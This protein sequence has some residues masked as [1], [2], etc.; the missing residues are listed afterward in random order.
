MQGRCLL[1]LP[2]DTIDHGKLLFELQALGINGIEL[3]WFV[4]YLSDRQQSV[5]YQNT[6]SILVSYLLVDLRG[7]YLALHF[8]Y[9]YC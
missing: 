1:T 2:F 8:L 7:L 5:H 3:A 6:L 9:N 4:D